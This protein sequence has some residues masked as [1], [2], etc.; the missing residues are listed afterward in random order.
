[1]SISHISGELVHIAAAKA[2]TRPLLV[3]SRLEAT[4]GKL[5]AFFF[6]SLSTLLITMLLIDWLEAVDYHGPLVTRYLMM[7]GE[8]DERRGGGGVGREGG[9]EGGVEI[10]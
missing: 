1:M 4:Q 5:W 8:R 7:R 2:L 6:L 10:R 3:L 9:R